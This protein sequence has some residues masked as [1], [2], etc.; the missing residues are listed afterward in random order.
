MLLPNIIVPRL[1][2][3]KF[4]FYSPDTQSDCQDLKHFKKY[5]YDIS[6]EFNSRGFRDV[7][8]PN[9]LENAIWCLGD[10]ATIGVGAPIAHS[11]PSQLTRLTGIPTINLGIRAIDNHTISDIA[12][13]IITNLQP[14]N[15]LILWSFFERRPVGS[16][17]TNIVDLSKQLIVENELDHY[18]YFTKCILNLDSISSKTNIVHGLIPN[19]TDYIWNDECVL[20]RIWDDVKDPT[21]P[22]KLEHIENIDTVIDKRILEELDTVHHVYDRLKR[23]SEWYKFKSKFMKNDIGKFD[24]LD[25]SRDGRHWDINTSKLIA[26]KFKDLLK[27]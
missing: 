23:I 10:S 21:W 26:N 11:W 17:H 3:K 25:L 19:S 12:R 8:W 13:E 22:E 9:D 4:R 24:Q 15:V 7:E 18:D 20:R 14:R 6:Y 16:I 5:P 27:K 2:N 1:V